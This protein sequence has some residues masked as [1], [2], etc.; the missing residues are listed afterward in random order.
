MVSLINM[1]ARG[2]V[3]IDNLSHSADFHR[4]YLA[5]EMSLPKSPHQNKLYCALDCPDEV[6]RRYR[7]KIDQKSWWTVIALSGL[8]GDSASKFNQFIKF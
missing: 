3:L 8:N 5:Y 1:S 7:K 2:L 4:W 6:W